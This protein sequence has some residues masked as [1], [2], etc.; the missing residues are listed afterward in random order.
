MLAGE[1]GFTLLLGP[2]RGDRYTHQKRLRGPGYVQHL[3]KLI[4]EKLRVLNCDAPDF[5]PKE[6][7]EVV[8]RGSRRRVDLRIREA[9]VPPD[10]YPGR[11]MSLT[12]SVAA[13]RYGDLV[14]PDR[15]HKGDDI[16]GVGLP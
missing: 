8:F 1:L 10:G 4:L 9:L 2:S 11:A 16:R 3:R 7:L 6:A 5:A 15:P 12:S 13:L 14:I